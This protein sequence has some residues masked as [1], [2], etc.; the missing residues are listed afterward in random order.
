MRDKSEDERLAAKAFVDYLFTPEA[1]REFV[2]C[3][4]RSVNPAVKKETDDAGTFPKVNT[5][6]TVDKKFGGW[7]D[8]QKKFFD[9]DKILDHIQSE[10]GQRRLDQQKRQ[11]R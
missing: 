3:G 6:W 4:F 10:V 8:A 11:S 2:A 9:A 1:Q 7:L 5:V